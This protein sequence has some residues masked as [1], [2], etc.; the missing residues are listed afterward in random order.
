M[1][2]RLAATE[3]KCRTTSVLRACHDFAANVVERH[4]V[5]VGQV[6][7]GGIDGSQRCSAVL[8][9][10]VYSST[11]LQVESS[12]ASVSAGHSPGG[13]GV[14]RLGRR[15]R[16]PL[17]DRQAGLPVAAS[18]HCELDRVFHTISPIRRSSL[19]FSG[20]KPA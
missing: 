17:A 5:E 19:V 15:E 16:Q 2:S 4:V 6:R 9:A 8:A 7:E 11:R 1:L 18:D 20:G 10:A 13:Q 12:T 3:N 14:G